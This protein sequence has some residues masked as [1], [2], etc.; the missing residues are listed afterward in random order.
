[1]EPSA[2]LHKILSARTNVLLTLI[3]VLTLAITD[4][5][6]SAASV[7]DTQHFLR[8][9]RHAWLPYPWPVQPTTNELA[10]LLDYDFDTI[11]LSFA[12]NYRGGNIDFSTLDRAVEM[13]GRRGKR[14]VLD[15]APS[16]DPSDNVVDQLSDGSFMTNQWDRNPNYAMIDVFDPVQREKYD[17]YV[18]LCVRRYGSNPH[19]A[20]FILGWGYMGETGYFIGDYLTDFANLGKVASGYSAFALAEF[21]RWRHLRKL[22]Y[23]TALP[24]PTEQGRNRDYIL[25]HQ[26]RSEFA[27]NVFQRDAAARAQALTRKPVGT[28]GYISVNANNYG[29]D[30]APTPNVDFYRSAVSAASFDLH[31]TLLDSAMGYEDSEVSDGSWQYTVACVERSLA[32]QIAHGAV[33][34]AM[35]VRD[36]ERCPPWETNFFPKLSKF[37][38]TQKWWENAHP[39]QSS[40]ALFQPTWSCS[41]LPFRSAS[42]PFVPQPEEQARLAKMIGLAESFGLSYQ[43]VTERELLAPRSLRPFKHIII[44][45][46]DLMPVILDTKSWEQLSHDR[47]VVP[48]MSGKNRLTRS[49]F[50]RILRQAGITPRLD[51][52]SDLVLAGRVN[53]LI[54]N[55][56]D[57]PVTV[58]LDD[59]KATARLA[60]MEF[61]VV[62]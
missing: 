57:Q 41:A 3:V 48:I 50:R 49:E 7:S 14:A 42:N 21:N 10:R 47:R 43:L 54:F 55:W 13:V 59:G 38:L 37:L 8:D 23:L 2:A 53:N 16:F 56:S 45:L 33:V 1:M 22:S 51:F 60:P 58:T 29:R 26:F 52:A 34:H 6:S 39:S 28:F 36:Y 19:L 61:R 9:H 62:P 15:I 24:R 20:G 18:E 30:W 17:H 35:L 46:W 44:P 5:V 31:R 4:R 40:V 27:G 12:G 11:G 32:R 25:F